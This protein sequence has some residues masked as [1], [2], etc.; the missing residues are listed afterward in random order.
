MGRQSVPSKIA[1]V[2]MLVKNL[3]FINLQKTHPDLDAFPPDGRLQLIRILCVSS[4]P[5]LDQVLLERIF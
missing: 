1:I 4:V 3:K 2:D 5:V